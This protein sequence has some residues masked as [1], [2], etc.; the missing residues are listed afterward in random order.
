MNWRLFQGFRNV[1][2]LPRGNARA[3]IWVMII[4][5]IGEYIPKTGFFLT[6]VQG[7]G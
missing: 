2:I 3:R 7:Y 6:G 1:Y 4:K 5:I